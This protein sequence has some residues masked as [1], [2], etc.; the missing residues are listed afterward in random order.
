[1][2]DVRAAEPLL[3]TNRATRFRYSR[4]TGTPR[5]LGGVTDFSKALAAWLEPLAKKVE[6]EHFRG[7]RGA[8]DDEGKT[9]V[10]HRGQMGSHTPGLDRHIRQYRQNVL[11]AQHVARPVRSTGLQGITRKLVYAQTAAPLL[12]ED[13]THYMVKPYHERVS[14]RLKG[15][16]HY[17]IQ[18]WAEMANQGLYHAAGIGHVHQKVHV[19]EHH[20]GEGHEREP[21]LVVHMS[22]GYVPFFRASYHDAG[23]AHTTLGHAVAKRPEMV[24]DAR[25]IAVMDFLTNNLDRH[26]GNLLFHPDGKILAID[27]S[28]SFQYKNKHKDGRPVTEQKDSL[29]NY[30]NAAPFAILRSYMPDMQDGGTRPWNNDGKRVWHDSELW[31]PA[32]DWWGSV[33]K[34]VR[35]RMAH[36]LKHIKSDIVRQHIQRNFNARADMLDDM[37]HNGVGNFGHYD[38]HHTE[39]PIHK[40]GEKA[41][42]EV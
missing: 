8:L 7:V 1:M 19:D 38:W 27:H 14:R 26:A 32:M 6:P 25:R 20:M 35:E 37:A 17:P 40:P 12:E 3:G 5:N 15:W 28:R 31:E 22:K 9:F 13:S 33:S 24:E 29:R 42:G 2:R 23:Q 41:E 18:G 34:K 36:E 4:R 30:V 16:M 11:E 10:D 21:A 39:V